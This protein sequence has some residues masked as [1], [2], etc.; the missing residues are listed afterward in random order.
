[1]TIRNFVE[2]YTYKVAFFFICVLNPLCKVNLIKVIFGS[3][4]IETICVKRYTSYAIRIDRT[5]E[6][7]QTTQS[8]LLV[9]LLSSFCLTRIK[10]R[11]IANNLMPSP[12]DITEVEETFALASL[13]RATSPAN[14]SSYL[15][16]PFLPALTASFRNSQS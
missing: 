13:H 16:S 5:I 7:A 2:R 4:I 9:G 8:L 3:G 6:D 12:Y 14:L 10:P 15:S 11:K 1:M